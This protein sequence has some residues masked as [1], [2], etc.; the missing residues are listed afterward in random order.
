MQQVAEPWL[1]NSPFLLG[2]DSFMTGGIIADR[3]DRRQAA[4]LFQGIQVMCPI[5]LVVLLTTGHIRVWMVIALS[6]VLGSS[7]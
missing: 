4:L 5:L 7:R 3:R 1:S 6:L 2:L